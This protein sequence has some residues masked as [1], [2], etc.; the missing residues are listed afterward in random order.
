MLYAKSRFDYVE[1]RGGV[2]GGFGRVAF[3]PM[4]FLVVCLVQTILFDPKPKSEAVV[5]TAT[6]NIYG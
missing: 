2:R 6:R 4:D 5:G 3:P 1:V